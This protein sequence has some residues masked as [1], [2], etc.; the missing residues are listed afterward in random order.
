MCA[1]RSLALSFT[2][3]TDIINALIVDDILVQ[4][5]R[6]ALGD[7]PVHLA[8]HDQGVDHVAAIIHRHK[9]TDFDLPRPFIDINYTD[10]SS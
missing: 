1:A 7:A 9:A 2:L 4:D 5:L 3:F 6:Q 10:I 8:V